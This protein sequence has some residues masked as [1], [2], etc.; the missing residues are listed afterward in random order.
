MYYF[1]LP[2]GLLDV[3][4]CY[5]NIIRKA[6]EHRGEEVKIIN[7][8]NQIPLNSKVFTEYD[9]FC[10]DVLLWRRPNIIVN[11]F[12]GVTPE[13][14]YLMHKGT[15][16][17]RLRYAAHRF[18]ERLAIDKTS[19]R[20]FVS[21][22]MLHHYQ[23]VYNYRKNDHFIMPCF[24]T[25]LGAE[26]FNK[27]RYS[28]PKFVYAGSMSAWQC[29][30]ATLELFKMIKQSVPSA[31]LDIYTSEQDKAKA[32]CM[33]HGVK[34]KIDCVPSNELESRLRN[35][36]YGFIV[37]DNSIINRVATPTK[38]SNYMGAGLIPVFSDSI[39][40]YKENI[41]PDNLYAVCFHDNEDAVKDIV[42][43]EQTGVDLAKI[44]KSYKDIFHR[45]W[46]EQFY[47]EQLSKVL[48]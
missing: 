15:F 23:S 16:L 43:I 31:T 39:Q 35:Y 18:M 46:N 33:K 34:S 7:H 32:L 11:W 3:T 48:P 24:N 38:L 20:L 12:Q 5:V 1:Y 10:M 27:E 17:S 14:T 28:S 36:K 13:E 8:L 42:R 47:V 45:Y 19:F 37:R 25:T 4:G 30:D 9:K 40:A 44:E 21:N 22:A 2:D 6:I 26:I 41:V 29:I